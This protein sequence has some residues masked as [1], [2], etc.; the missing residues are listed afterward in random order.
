MYPVK[1]ATRANGERMG[2]IIE[3]SQV[4]QAVQLLPKMGAKA[5]RRLTCTNSLEACSEYYLNNF[6]DKEVYFSIF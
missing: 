3:L 2:D 1:R 4:R 5:D 6:S